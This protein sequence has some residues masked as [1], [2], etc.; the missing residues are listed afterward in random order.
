M[1][2]AVNCLAITL[3]LPCPYLPQAFPPYRSFYKHYLTYRK[4]LFIVLVNLLKVFFSVCQLI[5]NSI[6]FHA[7][8]PLCFYAYF[9]SLQ[10][11]AITF[12]CQHSSTWPLLF[13]CVAS[14]LYFL[15]QQKYVMDYVEYHLRDITARF[16][17]L[18]TIIS[19]LGFVG[20]L[21]GFYHH[22][23]RLRCGFNK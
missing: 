23:V 6:C 12:L 16:Y 4:A 10:L 9:S 2:N 17:L 15:R 3:P 14:P 22:F 18:A 7:F 5:V 8:N 19:M 13:P 20:F 21:L 1:F 11:S